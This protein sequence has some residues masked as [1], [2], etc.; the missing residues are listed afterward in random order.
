[1]NV[2]RDE[3]IKMMKAFLCFCLMI[4]LS[5]PFALPATACWMAPEPFEIFSEDGSKVFVFIPDNNSITNAYAAVYEILNGERQIVYT[6][7]DLASFAYEG[8]FHFSTD[9]T[10]FARTFPAY[11]MSV[12]EVF[13]NGVRTREVMRNDFIKDYARVEAETSIGPM[14]TVKWNIEEQYSHNDTIT[15]STGEGNTLVFDLSTALFSTEDAL[16]D[17]V[18]TEVVPVEVLQT[19]P[20]PAEINE[21]VLPIEALSHFTPASVHEEQPSRVGIYIIEGS[22]IAFIGASIFLFKNRKKVK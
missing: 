7:E 14:Y 5:M 18:P 20:L 19:Q 12:F 1:M 11:G 4:A 17:I 3:V 22:A 6:V 8:N 10:H 2:Y 9:M 15:I 13:S 21:D 16:P